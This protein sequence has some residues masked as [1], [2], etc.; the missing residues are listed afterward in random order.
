MASKQ[1]LPP[2]SAP[3]EEVPGESRFSRSFFHSKLSIDSRRAGR[4]TTSLR[5][6]FAVSHDDILIL[7]ETAEIMGIVD[8]DG[9]RGPH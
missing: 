3:T 5:A 8:G 9:A 4:E 1:R 6:T 7:F 2:E